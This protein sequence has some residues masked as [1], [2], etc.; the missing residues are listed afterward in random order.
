LKN[1]NEEIN[2]FEN[3]E[4]D[5]VEYVLINTCGFLSSSRDEAEETIAYY[6]SI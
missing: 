3:P 1:Q 2:F 4:D 6:D 5:E